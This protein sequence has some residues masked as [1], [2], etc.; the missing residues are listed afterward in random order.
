[1]ISTPWKPGEEPIIIQGKNLTPSQLVKKVKSGGMTPEALGCTKSL[2]YEQM[3][4]LAL[5]Y[6][7]EL[8]RVAEQL[9]IE[10]GREICNACSRLHNPSLIESGTCI[11]CLLDVVKEQRDGLKCQVEEWKTSYKKRVDELKDELSERTILLNQ[12]I[13]ERDQLHAQ[14]EQHNTPSNNDWYYFRTYDIQKLP[15]DTEI[16]C[17]GAWHL[18]ATYPAY[19]AATNYQ[20]RTKEQI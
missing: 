12:T 8:E 14:V 5:F 1:M 19:D 10:Q 2:V 15:I 16:N 18:A 11:F 6:A 3:Y 4:E 20:A 17:H 9:E 13:S 7:T